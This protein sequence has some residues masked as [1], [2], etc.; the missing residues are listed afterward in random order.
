MAKPEGKVT[1]KIPR[2]LYDNL[3]DIIGDSGF[4]SVTDFVVYCLRDIVYTTK[5]SKEKKLSNK[6]I[7]SVRERLKSLGYL[8]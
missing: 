8:D 4:N 5:Q 1:L 7:D 3:Q 6:E 2:Q